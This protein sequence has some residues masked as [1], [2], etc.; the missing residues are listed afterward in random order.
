LVPHNVSPANE[1]FLSGT[2][3]GYSG[4]V[5]LRD[6]FL[7]SGPSTTLGPLWSLQWEVIFSLLLSF[8]T[9]LYQKNQIIVLPVML[10]L[11]CVGLSGE[12]EGF[13]YLPMFYFGGFLAISWEKVKSFYER[14]LQ[15]GLKANIIGSLLVLLAIFAITFKWTLHSLSQLQSVELLNSRIFQGLFAMLGIVLLLLVVQLW[16]PFRK[17][18]S[19][20]FFVFFGTI[21]F[22]LYLVHWPVVISTIFALGPGVTSAIVAFGFSLVFAW[23]FY[24]CIEKQSHKLARKILARK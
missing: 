20:K 17:L 10:F 2:P 21:S 7:L 16:T 12:G 5:M 9:F 15:T 22:S 8:Y 3:T 18:L 6:A 11:F 14:H 23:L 24:I 4:W 13:T 19:A 1:Y